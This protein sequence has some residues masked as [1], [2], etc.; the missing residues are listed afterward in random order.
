VGLARVALLFAGCLLLLLWFKLLSACYYM[1]DLAWRTPT[2]GLGWAMVVA[3]LVAF[4]LAS[5]G[6]AAWMWAR[7]KQVDLAHEILYWVIWI[8]GFVLLFGFYSNHYD[9]QYRFWDAPRGALGWVMLA[10]VVAGFAFSWWARV[11]LGPLWSNGVTR[12][13][14]HRVVDTG[15][16][17][18]VRHP[19][20]SGTM[21]AAF[22]TAV[23]HGTPSSFLGAAIMTAAWVIKARREE[24]FL[25]E[26]LGP[27]AYDVYAKRVRMLV[28]FVHWPS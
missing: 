9:V 2:S 21:L 14:D 17:A 25:R 28:P 19:I 16:Y 7:I 15:P 6:L 3:W 24:H 4:G 18:L 23:A 26:E 11:H 12:K 20:H 8:V 10:L 1:I 22:A 27:E 13:N 5:W